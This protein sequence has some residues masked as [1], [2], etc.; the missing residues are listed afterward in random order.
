MMEHAE[1]SKLPVLLK[2]HPRFSSII[3]THQRF[4]LFFPV[5][6][7]GG[8]PGNR[9]T[10]IYPF[11]SRISGYAFTASTSARG[12]RYAHAQILSSGFLERKTGIN[13]G[14]Y[15]TSV[16][17]GKKNKKFIIFSS[18]SDSQCLRS[19]RMTTR[20]GLWR[21]HHFFSFSQMPE[22]SRP[23]CIS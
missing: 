15:R 12:T 2:P 23:S 18:A 4:F 16:G 6:A 22:S 3:P 21:V 13:A 7:A 17:G 11:T 8:K 5:A 9:E 19:S 1:I 10:A 20:P 14:C